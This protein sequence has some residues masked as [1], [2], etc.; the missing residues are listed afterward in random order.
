LTWRNVKETFCPDFVLVRLSAPTL[1][2][3]SE[4]APHNLT[5][6]E[7]GPVS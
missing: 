7:R 3:E 4:G 2:F 5:Q 6:S 1:F